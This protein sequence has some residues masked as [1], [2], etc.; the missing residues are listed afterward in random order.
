MNRR[1]SMFKLK[2]FYLFTTSFTRRSKKNNKMNKL[3][4]EWTSAGNRIISQ[5]TE[6]CSFK[7]DL[8]N[9]YLNFL[10]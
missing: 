7:I 1:N 2:T 8:F 10:L 5:A 6:D 4:E 9:L 3:L